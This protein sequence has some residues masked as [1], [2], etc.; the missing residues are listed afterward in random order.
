M[1]PQE[2][3]DEVTSCHQRALNSSAFSGV[4]FPS[5]YT[6]H[7]SET[8]TLVLCC[9]YLSIYLNGSVQNCIFD[10]LNLAVHCPVFFFF[11]AW[12]VLQMLYYL[13]KPLKSIY[14]N[15]QKSQFKAECCANRFLAWNIP[16]FLTSQICEGPL[17]SL[18]FPSFWFPWQ[19]GCWGRL[20]RNS[21]CSSGDVTGRAWVDRCS[22]L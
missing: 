11:F 20:L 1:S 16:R 10:I 13:Y 8:E 5:V 19:S 6:H 21:L 15:K 14:E 12:N 17:P 9:F 4:I 3:T 22:G 7:R 2:Q 18:W